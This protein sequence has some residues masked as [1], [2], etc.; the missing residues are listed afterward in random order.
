[1]TNHWQESL[2]QDVSKRTAGCWGETC[3]TRVIKDFALRG[4][5]LGCQ[6][7]CRME[8][9]FAVDGLLQEFEVRGLVVPKL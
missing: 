5:S 6:M 7:G 1:M 4:G 2:L 8:I 3:S 9:V